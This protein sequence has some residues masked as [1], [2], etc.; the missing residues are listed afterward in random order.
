[1][2]MK[3]KFAYLLDEFCSYLLIEKALSNNTISSYNSDLLQYYHYL[4]EKFKIEDVNLIKIEHLN[5]FLAHLYDL[6][7]KANTIARKITAIKMFHKFLY[8]NNYLKENITALLNNLNL[9]K[10]YQLFF[11]RR[12]RFIIS[13]F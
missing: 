2:K 6:N 12:N 4:N 10:T 5:E 8:I 9:T 11:Y 7:L 13:N 3:D 1:M